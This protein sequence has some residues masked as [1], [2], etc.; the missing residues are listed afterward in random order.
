MAVAVLPFEGTYTQGSTP[1][2]VMGSNTNYLSV[3]CYID[4][5]L[6]NR[7]PSY[8]NINAQMF[9]RGSDIRIPLEFVRVQPYVTPKIALSEQRQER[10]DLRVL[11]LVFRFRR[12]DGIAI[13][14][15]Q[16]VDVYVEQK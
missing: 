11:P 15:G 2:V 8:E 4:E 6:I 16:M 5:I 14:P 7:L 13:Y 3:R 9:I 10:V 12:P 1:V